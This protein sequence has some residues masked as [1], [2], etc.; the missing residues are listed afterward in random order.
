MRY[1]TLK[2][3]TVICAITLLCSCIEDSTNGQSTAEL[4]KS[5]FLSESEIGIIAEGTRIKSFDEKS[6][7][8]V[9]D[10]DKSMFMI[11]N[12][13]Y[14]VHYTLEFEGELLLDNSLNT[15]YSSSGID[16]IGS[17][18]SSVTV[19]KIDTSDNRYW[20][21]DSALCIGFIVDF[22]F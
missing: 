17:G 3:L 22:S 19:V 7:Q 16:G 10:D 14:S 1:L 13:D 4:Y 5:A 8:I 18:T 6:E 11:S 20:L 2:I 9:F 15:L 21:W 12:M